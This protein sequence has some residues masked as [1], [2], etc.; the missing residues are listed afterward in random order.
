MVK[1][2]RTFF[3]KFRENVIN[4]K[5]LIDALKDIENDN[6]IQMYLEENEKL[7][8]ILSHEEIYWKQ[9]AKAFWLVKGDTNSKFFHADA[10]SRKKT[11]HI[12]VLKSDD[13]TLISNHENLSNLLR[14]YYNE[15][16]ADAEI[17][18]NIPDLRM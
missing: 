1:W 3:Y 12:S 15:V 13:G 5:V 17:A 18:A 14:D 11:N 8:D 16:F 10:S 7:N 9:R 4:Q 2:G 6:G